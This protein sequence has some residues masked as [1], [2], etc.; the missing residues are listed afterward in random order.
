MNAKTAKKLRKL[1]KQIVQDTTNT[2]KQEPNGQVV[3]VPDSERGVY[4]LLKE[5]VNTLEAHGRRLPM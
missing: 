3:V 5:S 2:H 1:A 4:M